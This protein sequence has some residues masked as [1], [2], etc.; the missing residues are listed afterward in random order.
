[1]NFTENLVLIATIMEVIVLGPILLE[2]IIE[3]RKLRHRVELSLEVVDVS[4]L[5]VHLA[6]L[7]ELLEDIRDLVD[8]ACNPQ[9]Y[10]A[11]QT[12]NEIL[13]AGAPLSGKKTLAERIAKE[14]AF[15]KIVIVHNPRNTD[16][17]AQARQLVRR[18]SPKKTMLL[19]PRL[20][21]IDEDKDEEIL[22][23]LGALM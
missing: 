1:M 14:A 22:V 5:S 8:R 7:D 20:D 12:G 4:A 2:F 17:L 3:R 11:L 21:L 9:A 23:E 13:I 6:G 16:A 18:A 10:A 19:I 15:E